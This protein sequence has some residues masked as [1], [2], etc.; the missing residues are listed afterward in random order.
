ML[1][2]LRRK[3]GSHHQGLL[4]V[5]KNWWWWTK[6][7]W[8][9]FYW[10]KLSQPIP[11][12]RANPK[13]SSLKWS[14]WTK[15]LMPSIP[16]SS[17]SGTNIMCTWATTLKWKDE[18]VIRAMMCIY[19]K[20]LNR[21]LKSSPFLLYPSHSLQMLNLEQ[22]FW[23]NHLKLTQF[24][25]IWWFCKYPNALHVLASTSPDSS[26]LVLVRLKRGVGPTFREDWNLQHIVQLSKVKM[27]YIVVT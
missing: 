13:L 3:E 25:Q 1:F 11:S 26:L 23:L 4:R 15:S 9:A 8:W 14:V 17:S 6:L 22:K 5:D 27:S 12:S 20:D 16:P 21:S 24:K 7:S 2:S 19:V 18:N 10:W